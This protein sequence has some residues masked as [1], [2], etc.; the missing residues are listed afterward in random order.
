MLVS[1]V[2]IEGPVGTE[3]LLTLKIDSVS[4]VFSVA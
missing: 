1:E 4:S 3:Y 2:I